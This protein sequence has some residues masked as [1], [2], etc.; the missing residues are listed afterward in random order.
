M[1]DLGFCKADLGLGT[2]SEIDSGSEFSPGSDFGSGSELGSDSAADTLPKKHRNNTVQQRKE[3]T[4]HHT[5][6]PY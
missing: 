3:K 6:V 2:G 4:N 5:K 1:F